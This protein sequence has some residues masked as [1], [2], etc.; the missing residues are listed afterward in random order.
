MLWRIRHHFYTSPLA[1]VTLNGISGSELTKEQE[2]V[3]ESKGAMYVRDGGQVPARFM[4]GMQVLMQLDKQWPNV[5]SMQWG[6]LEAREGEFLVADCYQDL[7]FMPIFPNLAFCTGYK[8]QII[9]K[10]DVA[11]INKQTISKSSNFY[12]AKDL[13]KCPVA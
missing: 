12:F 8:D 11:E 9:S 6:L 3:L 10:L 4:T 7:T 5:E 13:E 1:D 2:E